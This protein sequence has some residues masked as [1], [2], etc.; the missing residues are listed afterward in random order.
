MR[1]L[2]SLVLASL[3]PS[4]LRPPLTLFQPFLATPRTFE[5]PRRTRPPALEAPFV[6][7]ERPALPAFLAPLKAL[8]ATWRTFLA[9]RE[10][11]FM[12]LSAMPL[13]LLATPFAAEASLLMR[14]LVMKSRSATAPA[15]TVWAKRQ[16][17]ATPPFFTAL[18]KDRSLDRAPRI[19]EMAP[20]AAWMVW[21]MARM[22]PAP[23]M[24]AATTFSRT[25]WMIIIGR[26]LM[27]A[28]QTIEAIWPIL[29][30][31][32]ISTLKTSLPRPTT[33]STLSLNH[34]LTAL[35]MAP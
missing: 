9:P 23:G 6:R 34:F 24:R 14:K 31:P 15:A 26:A 16:A 17:A 5:A 8:P 30:Q 4:F 12:I 21:M 28:P 1:A 32:L 10:R 20:Q 33:S 22:A 35:M 27:T 2:P 19:L 3:E 11:A 13:S 18:R 29:R 25:S 7:K